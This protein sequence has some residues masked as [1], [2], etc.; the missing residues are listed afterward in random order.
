MRFINLT[1]LVLILLVTGVHAQSDYSL[2]EKIYKKAARYGDLGVAKN[3]LY[4]MMELKPENTFLMDTL[5]ILYFQS[6]AYVQSVLVTNEILEKDP[7]KISALEIKAISE[8]AL[9]YGKEALN[10]YEK[11]YAKTQN[12]YHL[13]QI[14]SL[15]YQLKRMAE[16]YQH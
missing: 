13:Y 1:A 2:Q 10:D 15:Q 6:Q 4:T 16:Q 11:L 9:G 5:A 7:S 8:S 14:A 3:A 12:V